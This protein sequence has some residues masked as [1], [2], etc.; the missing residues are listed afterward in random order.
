MLGGWDG[1]C[2]QRVQRRT[3]WWH[4]S[5]SCGAWVDCLHYEWK[6]TES[7]R[8]LRKKQNSPNVF[9]TKMHKLTKRVNVGDANVCVPGNAP[10]EVLEIVNQ[11]FLFRWGETACNETKGINGD[12]KRETRGNIDGRR[13]TAM[14]AASSN[15]CSVS[16]CIRLRDHNVTGYLCNPGHLLA[17][18]SILVG[19]LN[20]RTLST[21]GAVTWQ[22]Q[23]V[24]LLV[25]S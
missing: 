7:I 8:A 5:T 17:F 22:L 16:T 12:V 4:Q 11:M 9:K 19:L 1:A 14:M 24:T 21:F 10:V 20:L 3:K 13:G 15:N 23:G 25:R 6:C 2:V 18:Q